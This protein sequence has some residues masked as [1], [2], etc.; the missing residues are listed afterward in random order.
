MRFRVRQANRAD[1]G[2]L[3]DLQT[4]CC[5]RYFGLAAW[6]NLLRSTRRALGWFLGAAA[7]TKQLGGLSHHSGRPLCPSGFD[8][9]AVLRWSLPRSNGGAAL[10]PSLCTKLWVGWRSQLPGRP[11]S[12]CSEGPLIA[13]ASGALDANFAS[14][15][16]V[17][18]VGATTAANE[19]ARRSNTAN[20][21]AT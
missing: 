18:S 8:S 16:V 4:N 10:H 20:A 7:T 14:W 1:T 5:C 13:A 3:R 21:N 11:L 6:S 15:F 9:A 17:S 19:A 12:V 2:P